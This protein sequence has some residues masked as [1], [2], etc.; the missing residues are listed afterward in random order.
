MCVLCIGVALTDEARN[1]PPQ[2]AQLPDAGVHDLQLRCRQFPG[3]A[4]RVTRLRRQQADDLGERKTHCL[5]SPD[6]PQ[7]FR[8]RLAVTPYPSTR[9][10]RLGDESPALVVTDR[11][12][13]NTGRCRQAADGHGNVRGTHDDSGAIRALDSVPQYRAYPRLVGS[14]SPDISRSP[15]ASM[16]EKP[17]V[18]GAASGALGLGAF[19]AAVGGCCGAPWAVALLGV[20]GAVGLARLAFLLPYALIGAAILLGVA[21]RSAY[22]PAAASADGACALKSGRR[23]L[24]ILVWVAALLVAALGVVALSPFV[25]S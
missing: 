25:S 20:T 17:R 24:R 15:Q 7:A 11:L 8:V 5:G 2:L 23:P 12:D 13:V 19:A 10:D 18:I 6:E 14:G 16:A 4:A 22:R 1:L 3:C 9:A 21:F